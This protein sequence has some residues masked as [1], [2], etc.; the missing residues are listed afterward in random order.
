MGL[1]G[2]DGRVI[3]VRAGAER[4]GTVDDVDQAE[5]SGVNDD[6]SVTPRT[7][8]QSLRNICGMKR[9]RPL[10]DAVIVANNAPSIHGRGVPR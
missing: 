2:A 6:P 1:V 4:A 9:V 8:I 7:M 5:R 10:I 3:A